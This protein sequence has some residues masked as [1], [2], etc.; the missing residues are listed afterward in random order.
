MVPAFFQEA[1]E[2]LIKNVHTPFY[3]A[4]KQVA[5]KAIYTGGPDDVLAEKM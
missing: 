2:H 3:E 1:Q 4:M 5:G